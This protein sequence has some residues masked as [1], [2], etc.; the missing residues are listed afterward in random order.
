MAKSEIVLLT[1]CV[2]SGK[3]D[4]ETAEAFASMAASLEG[5]NLKKLSKKQRE[6]V[7]GVHERLGLDPGAAN[8]ATTGAVRVTD[9]DRKG[10]REWAATLGPKPLKPPTRRV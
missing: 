8:L 2:E 9:A 1:E 6:W 5:R 4:D 3:L 10:L 7:L